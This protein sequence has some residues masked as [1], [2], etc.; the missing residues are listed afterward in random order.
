MHRCVGVSG[1]DGCA[2][3]MKGLPS[4]DFLSTSWLPAV[5]DASLQPL[6]WSGGV[7]ANTWMELLLLHNETMETHLM[8]MMVRRKSLLTL[9]SRPC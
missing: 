9:L 3:I 7:L 4:C 1:V 6:D 5:G 2:P 8:M